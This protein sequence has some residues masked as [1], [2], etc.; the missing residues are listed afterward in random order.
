M[1]L[2]LIIVLN[3]LGGYAPGGWLE[4]SGIA[5]GPGYA[6]VAAYLVWCGSSGGWAGRRRER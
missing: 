4:R 1:I 2:A 5:P 6:I 3:T